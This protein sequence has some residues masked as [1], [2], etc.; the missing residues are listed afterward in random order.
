MVNKT[1]LDFLMTEEQIHLISPFMEMYNH[2]VSCKN[3][4]ISIGSE[5][6]TADDLDFLGF[7][8]SEIETAHDKKRK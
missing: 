2:V 4:G 5:N 6:F 7:I 3:L 8:Q 1:P